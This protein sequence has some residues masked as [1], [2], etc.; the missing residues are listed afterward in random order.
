MKQ[1][2]S[3]K[4]TY[5]NGNLVGS[6]EQAHTSPYLF[7]HSITDTLRSYFTHNGVHIFRAEAHLKRLKA[8]CEDLNI[9][10]KWNISTIIKDLY[11]LVHVNHHKNALIQIIVSMPVNHQFH[12]IGKSILTIKTWDWVTPKINNQLRVNFEPLPET[13]S[14]KFGKTSHHLHQ[15]FEL[16]KKCEASNFQN[17]ILTLG[18]EIL[19]GIHS[20]LFIEKEGKLFTSNHEQLNEGITKNTIIH[21][22]KKLEIEIISKKLYQQ[23]L[24]TADSAFLVGT[25]TEVAGI[26]T[27]ESQTLPLDWH[28]SLGASLSISYKHLVMERENYEVII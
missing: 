10:F 17:S 23:D 6:G 21:L 2:E 18:D 5:V 1:Q 3:S 15:F 20:H 26:K 16:K 25:S 7:Y 28:E 9:P 14:L 4:F 19:Q 12:E 27:V 8:H 11:E 24:L 13:L 22:C